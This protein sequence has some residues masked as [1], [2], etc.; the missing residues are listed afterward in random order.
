M[1]CGLHLL[2]LLAAVLWGGVYPG[3]KLGLRETPVLGFNLA[4]SSSRCGATLRRLGA[5][6]RL[7][8]G[9]SAVAAGAQS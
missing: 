9:A 3:T 2:P 7:G 4:A 1:T 6:S 5:A 8:P